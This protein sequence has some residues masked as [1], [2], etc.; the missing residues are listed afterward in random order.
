MK[1]RVSVDEKNSQDGGMR[2]YQ[3]QENSRP[4]PTPLARPDLVL[5]KNVL[6]DIRFY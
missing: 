3:S 6:H 5:L 2:E 4:L 1:R